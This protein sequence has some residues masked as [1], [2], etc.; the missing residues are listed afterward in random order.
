VRLRNY[1]SCHTSAV[2]AQT[3]FG[4]VFDVSV[5]K[6]LIMTTIKFPPSNHAGVMKYKTGQ[7]ANYGS[8]KVE[9]NRFFHYTGKGLREM[10][11][12]NPNEEQKKLAAEL[13]KKGESELIASGHIMCPLVD[14]IEEFL[15]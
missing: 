6:Q 13:H 9:N 1:P 8:I 3:A 7:T 2:I 4:T 10:F 15:N 5:S 12:Q 14:E 11:P